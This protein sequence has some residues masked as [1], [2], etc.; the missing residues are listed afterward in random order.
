LDQPLA[1]RMRPKHIDDIVGQKHLLEKGKLLRRII[2]SKRLTSI[3]FYG[4]PGTGKTSLANAIAGTL[5]IEFYEINAVSSGKKDMEKVVVE[6]KKVGRAVMFVDEVHRFN[7]AQQDYLLPFLESGLITL[8]AATTENPFFSV[9]GA[10]LSRCQILELEPVT[11]EDIKAAITRAIADKERGLGENNVSITEEAMDHFVHS[12]NGDVRSA[13]N[14]VEMAVLSTE[15]D[16]TGVIQIT[17][18]IAEECLQKKGMSYDKDGDMHYDILSAFQKSIRGSDTDAALHYLGRLI[19]AGDEKS[20]VRRLKVI[21]FE[22]ISLANPDAVMF[23]VMACDAVK[24]LGFPE[25][26]IPLANAVVMLCNSP[27]SNNAY[28]GLDMAI[29]DIQNGKAG[30]IPK[31]LRDAH[32]KSAKKLGNGVD[33]LY[34]HSYPKGLFGGWVAQQYLPDKLKDRSYYDPKKSGK[35][36]EE[37]FSAGEKKYAETYHRLK[38]AQKKALD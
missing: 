16:G 23:T 17:I 22:D 24:E 4:P 3:L 8:I 21:A 20:I 31:H 37:E 2:D 33:Y 30:S 1:Y 28:K 35:P 12:T 7:K 19:L 9:N 13:L 11:P 29:A 14:A 26:R 15:A 25:A 38:K 36:G 32:Y 27:K 34:P 10:I 6:A 5:G 18:E